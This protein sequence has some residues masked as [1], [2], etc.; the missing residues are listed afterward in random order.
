LEKTKPVVQYFKK[1]PKMAV[2]MFFDD[3]EIDQ[4]ATGI[5]IKYD[6]RGQQQTDGDD[7]LVFNFNKQGYCSATVERKNAVVG[8]DCLYT[9]RPYFHSEYTTSKNFA[10]I[11]YKDGTRGMIPVWEKPTE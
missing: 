11:F 8:V 10:T 9:F 4:E 5:S 3:K 2:K 1:E 6:W 7:N